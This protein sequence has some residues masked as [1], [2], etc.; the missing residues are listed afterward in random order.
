MHHCLSSSGRG[1]A[2]LV[3]LAGLAFYGQPA[4]AD[5]PRIVSIG[6]SVT[7]IVYALGAEDRL[8]AVDT[9]STFPAEARALPSVGYMRALAAEGV[10][11]LKPDLILAIEG[12]GPPPVI[13]VLKAATVPFVE[14]PEGHTP[15]RILAKIG[16]VGA[17]LNMP[18]KAAA[19][20]VTVKADLDAL[21]R[22]SGERPGVL[23]LLSATGGKPMVA[24]AGTAA[25]AIIALAGGRN[26]FGQIEGYK[27]VTR[28]ALIAASPDIVLTM[29]RHG[30]T[31]DKT[32]LEIPGMELT[33]AGRNKALISMD[34]LYLLGFGPR[35]AA[36]AR[37]LAD[38]IAQAAQ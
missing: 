25:D 33:P 14:I 2:A 31:L 27:P 28:E 23:F 24:G 17:A 9:T 21:P 36:A 10:L 35:T 3:L 15:E 26:V 22:A 19:L 32:A 8:V 30:S 12:S 11:S 4:S 5:A 13:D 16:A 29:Q 37:E 18:E 38:R 20:I 6:G 34:G 1:L 7:E